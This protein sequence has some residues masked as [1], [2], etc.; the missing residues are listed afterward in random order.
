MLKPLKV[1]ATLWD[2]IDYGQHL[3]C[4]WLFVPATAWG[5]CSR[6]RNPRIGG[7]GTSVKAMDGGNFNCMV[8]SHYFQSQVR[9]I[10]GLSSGSFC[11]G[12]LTIWSIE[13]RLRHVGCLRGQDGPAINR[14][15]LFART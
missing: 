11:K 9:D 7:H 14:L 3:W 8:S 13:A 10:M 5:Q 4:R 1:L 6:I 12:N 15:P 2:S